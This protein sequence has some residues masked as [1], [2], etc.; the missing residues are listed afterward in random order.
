MPDMNYNASLPGTPKSLSGF[1]NK[2]MQ[3]MD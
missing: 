1:D 3:R 2:G